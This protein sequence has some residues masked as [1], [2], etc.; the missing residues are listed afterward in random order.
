MKWKRRWTLCCLM[1]CLVFVQCGCAAETSSSEAQSETQ[2]GTQEAMERTEET[3][4]QVESAHTWMQVDFLD[5]GKADAIVIQTQ[6]H[7]VVIDCG[8]KE[9]GMD[10]VNFLKNSGVET[11]DYLII[12]HYDQ[13]HVGGA[14][15]VLRKVGAAAVIGP[16]YTENSS[17]YEKYTAAMSDTGITPMLL[18]EEYAFTL[19]D[20]A[21]VVYGSNPSAYT[22]NVDNNSSLVVRVEHGENVFLF[23]GD[24]TEQRLAEFPDMGTCTLL[25]VPYH[26]RDIANLSDFLVQVQPSI[27]VIS[28]VESEISSNTIAALAAVDAAVYSTAANGNITVVSDGVSLTVSS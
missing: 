17:E 9:D 15:K 1:V 12:S 10:V 26:G 8:E 19:D 16:N 27:A 25:K 13:D 18:T 14:A 20:V 5:V 4:A 3:E 11:L 21:F 23:T 6:T 2:A 24:A 7:T 28:S 22:E